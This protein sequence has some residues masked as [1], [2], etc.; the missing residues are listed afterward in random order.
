MKEAKLG[1]TERK[2][3]KK[4]DPG[5][6]ERK[7]GGGRKEGLFCFALTISLLYFGRKGEEG[8]KKVPHNKTFLFASS[9]IVG[10]KRER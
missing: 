5:W 6:K 9:D 2:Q 4:L 3:R 1:L 7:K 8:R 10:Y